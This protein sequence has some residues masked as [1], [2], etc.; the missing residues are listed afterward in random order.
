MPSSAA[1]SSPSATRPLR[2]VDRTRATRA[3]SLAVSLVF[4]AS[5]LAYVA[6]FCAVSF[7]RYDAFL[8]HALDMGN[9]EQAV[10]N[11][12][13]GHPF[14]FTNMRQHIPVE[15]FGTTTRLSFHVEPILLPLSLLQLLSAGPQA[16][17]VVQTV[18]LASGALPAR[19]LARRHLP[20]S[21]LAEVIFPLAYLLF[22]AMQA[23]NLYEFHPVTLTAALL[24]WAI[25]FADEQRPLAFVVTAVAAMACKEEIGL[26]VALLALWSMRRGMPPRVAVPLAALSAAWALIAVLVIV[27]AAQRA[28]HSA[29]TSSPYLARYLD[30]RLTAPGQYEHVTVGD[31]LRYWLAYPDRLA[32]VVLG[33]PKQG[34][35]QRILAPVA[36]LAVFS[37]STLLI[38]LPSFLLILF[39]VDQHMYGGV[40]HYSAELVGV[41]V[42][43][44]VFGLARLAAL[45]PRRGIPPHLVV[46]GGSLVVLVV[47]LANARVNGFA[48]FSAAF[49]WPAITP[50]VLLGERMLARIPPDA[51]VSAQDTLDPHL[52]DRAAIYLFPDTQDAD[53]VALDASA[54]PIPASPASLQRTVEAML[55]SRRWDVLFADDGYLLLHRRTGAPARTAPTLPAAFYRFILPAHPAIATPLQVAAGPG[56][57]MLGYTISRREVVNLRSPDVVLTT[58][59]TATRPVTQPFT[60]TTYLTDVHGRL[61]D[62]FDQQSALAWLPSTAWPP[63]RVVAVSSTQMG[64]GSTSPGHLAACVAIHDTAVPPSSA[65]WTLG[66]KVLHATPASGPHRLIGGR[67]LCLGDIPVVF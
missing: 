44:A 41:V 67:V 37:P 25:D 28:G 3:A 2:P 48:P 16:L 8:M 51:A 32:G 26:V 43:S 6:V 49:E 57:R 54:S 4:W 34:Y 12:I 30:R 31:V 38:S 24:L 5:V 59:W 58:Y 20:G 64:I 40:G 52:S 53:Y 61:V 35:V 46:A 47:S 55:R 9:M 21:R 66:L 7:R 42:A 10:W 11:T 15:A 17:L 23:A 33:P 63:G 65:A 1:L 14:R 60:M 36:Y 62:R 50:H 39:S 45:A 19:R 13:H 18:V 27:P 22:P 29:V 56:L